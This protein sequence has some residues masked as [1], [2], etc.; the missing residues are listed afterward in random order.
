L[1]S[2]FAL[3]PLLNLMSVLSRFQGYLVV[4]LLLFALIG[5][6][7]LAITIAGLVGVHN[8]RQRE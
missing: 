1:L 6:L 2:F 4:V 8:S 5:Q 3:R 7:Y